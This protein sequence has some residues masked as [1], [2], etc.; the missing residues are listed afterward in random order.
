[1]QK[2]EFTQLYIGGIGLISMKSYW[3]IAVV[4]HVLKL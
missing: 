1:M 3:M 4:A 2:A